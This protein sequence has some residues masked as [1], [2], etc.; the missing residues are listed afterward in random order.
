MSYKTLTALALLSSAPAI[1]Q[2]PT[3]EPPPAVVAVPQLPAV[4]PARLAV[5]QRVIELVY[6]TGALQQAWNMSPMLQTIMGMRIADFGLPFPPPQGMPAD[7]TIGQMAAQ[8]DPHFAERMRISSQVIAEET[9]R[10]FTMIEPEFRRVMATVY[11]RR[12]TAPELEEIGRFYA[13]PAGRRYAGEALTI[14]Q[15]PEFIRGFMMMMPRVAL[16]MPAVVQRVTAAT[17]HLP[18]PGGPP[19]P[20]EEGRRPRRPRN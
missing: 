3:E 1:A 20:P 13:T 15:D 12:F 10:I 18:P 6:P 5:A 4:D 19:S 8:H 7:A 11:A 2:P 14:M 16:Q 17:A 9:G